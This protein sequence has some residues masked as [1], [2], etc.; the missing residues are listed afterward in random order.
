[1]GV[2]TGVAIAAM[3]VY[4]IAVIIIIIIFIFI[5]ITIII[6]HLW[7]KRS[8]VN[9]LWLWV[10][11]KCRQTEQRFDDRRWSWCSLWAAIPPKRWNHIWTSKTSAWTRNCPR[12]KAA[13]ACFP[14]TANACVW[15]MNRLYTGLDREWWHFFQRYICNL[16]TVFCLVSTLPLHFII[17]H[18]KEFKEKFKVFREINA[19]ITILTSEASRLLIISFM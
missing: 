13:C 10:W 5:F 4:I 3:I 15:K 2:V 12:R 14:S 18:Y 9:P 8:A 1:M 19:K 6:I 17:A 7:P 11:R 16:V